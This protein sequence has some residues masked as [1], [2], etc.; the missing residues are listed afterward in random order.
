MCSVEEII[1]AADENKNLT[2]LILPWQKCEGLYPLEGNLTAALGA[3]ANTK[4]KHEWTIVLDGVADNNNEQYTVSRELQESISQAIDREATRRCCY[5]PING[6]IAVV[7]KENFPAAWREAME[8]CIAKNIWVDVYEHDLE[9]GF[10]F[11]AP[12]MAVRHHWNNR[13]YSFKFEIPAESDELRQVAKVL[14]D[15]VLSTKKVH[16]E[17]R[18]VQFIVRGAGIT[19]EKLRD[20]MAAVIGNDKY[21]SYY[22]CFFSFEPNVL[23][24]D[25]KGNVTKTEPDVAVITLQ[26]RRFV[27]V[28]MASLLDTIVIDAFDAK[29]KDFCNYG[30][31][32]VGKA[33]PRKMSRLRLP[34]GNEL[35]DEEW[36]KLTDNLWFYF[37]N[38]KFK[39]LVFESDKEGCEKLKACAENNRKKDPCPQRKAYKW[40]FETTD[41]ENELRLVSQAEVYERKKNEFLKTVG[42]SEYGT[43]VKDFDWLN[44]GKLAEIL[45]K[46]S[47]QDS[48][49]HLY[50]DFDTEGALES[51]IRKLL[52]DTSVADKRGD[53]ILRTSEDIDLASLLPSMKTYFALPYHINDKREILFV[54]DE[55][56]CREYA[57]AMLKGYLENLEDKGVLEIKPY[58]SRFCMK[59]VLEAAAAADSKVETLRVN[60]DESSADA[61]RQV[62]IDFCKTV[63]VQRNPFALRLVA[64][65]ITR[66]EVLEEI[67][68]D[69][70]CDFSQ[71]LSN[72]SIILQDGEIERLNEKGEHAYVFGHYEVSLNFI[73]MEDFL[74]AHYINGHSCD[75]SE[76][77]GERY[78]DLPTAM[79]FN[80]MSDP[81]C[82]AVHFEILRDI[83]K[84]EVI[85]GITSMLANQ[86]EG[87]TGWTVRFAGVE[88]ADGRTVKEI[89]D[90]VSKLNKNE[91]S[92]FVVP[93]YKDN[94]FL[95]VDKDGWTRK[96]EMES[97]EADFVYKGELKRNKLQELLF[98]MSLPTSKAKTLALKDFSPNRNELKLI[99]DH[100]NR[101]GWSLTGGR[102]GKAVT[103]KSM[104]CLSTSRSERFL[105]K[106]TFQKELAALFKEKES[107]SL[108][109]YSWYDLHRLFNFQASSRDKSVRG[110]VPLKDALK[111]VEQNKGKTLSLKADVG[112]MSESETDEFIKW[113]KEG[114]KAICED[115]VPAKRAWRLSLENLS[116]KQREQIMT[117]QLDKTAKREPVFEE[118]ESMLSVRTQIPFKPKPLKNGVLTIEASDFIMSDF[119][120]IFA[121][122]NELPGLKE[123]VCSVEDSV[124][125]YDSDVVE[126]VAKVLKFGLNGTWK[127]ITFPSKWWDVKT[128]AEEI[129][130]RIREHH[131]PYKVSKVADGEGK[132]TDALVFEDLRIPPLTARQK[133]YALRFKQDSEDEL[134]LN[135]LQ[136]DEALT[137]WFENN[138]NSAHAWE[139]FTEVLAEQPQIQ[140]VDFTDLTDKDIHKLYGT[141]EEWNRLL[142][143]SGTV[144]KFVSARPKTDDEAM[145]ASSY[146][147]LKVRNDVAWHLDRGNGEVRLF[148]N[149]SMCMKPTKDKIAVTKDKRLLWNRT[150]LDCLFKIQN[151]KK[152]QL[153]DTLKDKGIDIIDFTIGDPKTEW[154]T[155]YGKKHTW[156]DVWKYAGSENFINDVS[157]FGT[158]RVY[159]YCLGENSRAYLSEK[160]NFE[161]IGSG[162]GKRVVEITFGTDDNYD[163]FGS[164]DDDDEWG[165]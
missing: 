34:K 10:D 56:K 36:Q 159:E 133:P 98:L 141:I 78:K 165:D 4:S 51:A 120:E 20:A 125:N 61:L 131:L 88:I 118:D 2:K 123:V 22:A 145:V 66:D 24:R 37:F 18:T 164:E 54:T 17:A 42:A 114:L 162:D 117:L 151:D 69:F 26:A 112:Y 92:R 45:L 115:D 160:Q 108:T 89:A 144:F 32:E 44:E 158:V 103:G 84:E 138:K 106:E 95:F 136:F 163:S 161:F 81:R 157:E 83:T 1:K 47:K 100:G 6:T 150:A 55:N 77:I 86:K 46:M 96:Q 15:Y 156:E 74:I 48:K 19:P 128:L 82:K 130:E 148:K 28:K 38:E 147:N 7:K 5:N 8:A 73:R 154:T 58:W 137:K 155:S 126:A 149:G 57:S 65:R 76:E 99:L 121:C 85:N 64:P 102:M 94:L 111:L 33:N 31:Y 79:L 23:E 30:F 109:K 29:D 63:P 27:L 124:E 50:V 105:D 49:G 87:R 75:G 68:K 127:R 70:R 72:K 119:D 113:I 104:C 139:E 67:I 80:C 116:R 122:A 146:T 52:E 16:E 12:A 143:V 9:V 142:N 53:W 93:M 132:Q 153:S 91:N 3:I 39:D 110:F 41:K 40:T 107:E 60:V 59:E 97:S 62:L 21:W 152:G 35:T 134:K 11:V 43:T 129:Q 71:S 140:C 90:A 25:E 14:A 101:T 13:G 135:T